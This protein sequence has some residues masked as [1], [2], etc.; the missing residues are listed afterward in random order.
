M[1]RQHSFHCISLFAAVV[2]LIAAPFPA[3][4]QGRA[5]LDGPAI[6][7]YNHLVLSVPAAKAPSKSVVA[8]LVSPKITK[9]GLIV[10]G[11]YGEG[12]LLRGG[13]PAG[14][15]STAGASLWAAG[16]RAASARRD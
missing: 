10:G 6:R 13:K 1:Q 15:Y 8:V 5:A 9:A 14:Y 11:Q 2:A 12:V 16:G 4:A 7:A 3:T